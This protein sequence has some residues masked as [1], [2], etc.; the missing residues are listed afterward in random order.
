MKESDRSFERDIDKNRI[1]RSAL[2]QPLLL[3]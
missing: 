3:E 1:E 2:L